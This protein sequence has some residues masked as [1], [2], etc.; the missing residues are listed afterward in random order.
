MLYEFPHLIRSWTFGAPPAHFPL[1]ILQ[2]LTHLFWLSPSV[3]SGQMAIPWLMNNG[4]RLFDDILE[5][6]A[7][8]SSLLRR[9]GAGASATWTRR[10]QSSC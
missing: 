4:M 2:A 8:G 6:H 5:Q 3:H 9:G 10:I 1:L 7:P